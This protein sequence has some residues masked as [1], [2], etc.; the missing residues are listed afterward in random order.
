M[1]ERVD[2]VAGQL[3]APFQEIQLEDEAEPGHFAAEHFDQLRD[4]RGSSSG[5]QDIVNDKYVLSGCYGVLMNL[6]HIFAIFE[7]ILDAGAL[8]GK[9]LFFSNRDESVAQSVGNRGSDDESA[10]FDP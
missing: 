2:V 7:R 9:F 6:E 10:G 1:Q 8:A 5:G 3:L 4:S